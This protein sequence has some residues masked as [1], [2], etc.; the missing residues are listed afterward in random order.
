M[1]EQITDALGTLGGFGFDADKTA[2]PPTAAPGPRNM[3][4]LLAA[5]ALA[6]RTSEG[7]IEEDLSQDDAADKALRKFYELY[8]HPVLA[9]KL[10]LVRDYEIEIEDLTTHTN[11]D[12]G[13][14]R[15]GV[16][17]ATRDVFSW[18]ATAIDP[19]TRGALA[20]RPAGREEWFAN[21]APEP[22]SGLV[23]LG[24]KLDNTQRFTLQTV[25]E[26]QITRSVTLAAKSSAEQARRA[27]TPEEVD[28]HLPQLRTYGI[29]LMD[30][31]RLEEEASRLGSAIAAEALTEAQTPLIFAE[32][33]T[34]GMRVDIGIAQDSEFVW[35]DAGERDIAYGLVRGT[36]ISVNLDTATPE[37]DAL[38]ER[39]TAYFTPLNRFLDDPVATS[40]DGKSAVV[41]GRPDVVVQETLL[42]WSGRALS[43]PRRSRRDEFSLDPFFAPMQDIADG[44]L[45]IELD[46]REATV[47]PQE[48]IKDGIATG[49]PPLWEQMGYV[50]GARPVYLNRG[51]P[52][53]REARV[54]YEDAS[55]PLA[56]GDGYL[57][58]GRPAP[59]I[60]GRNEP[61][62]APQLLLPATANEPLF[63]AEDIA[64]WPGNSVDTLI[65]RDAGYDEVAD[66]ERYILPPRI[67]VTTAE[68]TGVLADA[69]VDS[70]QDGAITRPKG[71]FSRRSVR[72]VDWSGGFPSAI[73]G[74]IAVDPPRPVQ[75][76]D[77]DPDDLANDPL[78][79]A[80][81]TSVLEQVTRG[82]VFMQGEETPVEFPYYPD[83]LAVFL[84]VMPIRDDRALLSEP[85]RIRVLEEGARWPDL[86]P[87]LIQLARPGSSNRA[88][89]VVENEDA[90]VALFLLDTD[91]GPLGRTVPT[92]RVEVAEGRSCR[93][94][95]WFAPADESFIKG[96]NLIRLAAA[97]AMAGADRFKSGDAALRASGLVDLLQ[98]APLRSL[99]TMEHL[100]LTN[101]TQRPVAAPTLLPVE[102]PVLRTV[103]WD[104][105]E[106][107]AA[108]MN[109][110][111]PEAGAPEKPA[112]QPKQATIAVIDDAL[113]AHG[114][115][116][117]P[118]DPTEALDPNATTLMFGGDV[119]VHR[120]STAELRI[121]AKWE[122]WTD[123]IT[124]PARRQEAEFLRP[125][126]PTQG[127]G[128]TILD[129]TQTPVEN[130]PDEPNAPV[131]LLRD[132]AGV[133]RCLIYDFVDT[134]ARELTVRI[135]ALSRHAP[136]FPA[137]QDPEAFVTPGPEVAIKVP[138][139]A[140]PAEPSLAEPMLPVFSEER[141]TIVSGSLN[142]PNRTGVV[143]TRATKLRFFLNRPWYDAGQGQRLAVLLWDGAVLD[144]DTP[145]E[146]DKVETKPSDIPERM[147]T[148]V[149]LHGRDPKFA[150]TSL[151]DFITGADFIGV[152]QTDRMAHL[153]LPDVADPSGDT[154]KVSAVLF[155]AKLD[156]VC[157][158]WIVDVPMA[159]RRSYMPFV[160]LSLAA[161]Q[162][163]SRPGLE[164]SRPIEAFG[165]IPPAR[166]AR[167][168]VEW[169]NNAP[170]DD[171][172]IMVDGGS[173]VQREPGEILQEVKATADA[174]W[175][176]VLFVERA[177][178]AEGS[179]GWVPKPNDIGE[180]HAAFK[181]PAPIQ[182]GSAGAWVSDKLWDF[183]LKMPSD[184][185]DL[186]GAAD[187]A[188]LIREYE[189][190]AADADGPA[191]DLD[192]AS[193]QALKIVEAFHT[194]PDGLSSIV[195][196]KTT[197][198]AKFTM[199]ELFG[200]EPSAPNSQK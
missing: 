114:G 51:G 50:L 189:R 113:K 42:T 83:P 173:Y 187:R 4:E 26:E 147:R 132:D 159:A 148:F 32:T 24:E 36:D 34:I 7:V 64:K 101:A 75:F 172:A 39:T 41:G 17:T 57:T 6:R 16:R 35:F 151:P 125:F 153:T 67:D 198:A 59:L 82:G 163:N 185:A 54:H 186:K 49:V 126:A 81:E 71:M 180:D 183:A 140:R 154:E 40:P 174:P 43:L 115:T 96:H 62:A 12:A 22:S 105:S 150:S 87:C 191:P 136:V 175:L 170:S 63:S 197:F 30:R 169:E 181:Q 77:N 188:V 44:P 5:A 184:W 135:A 158:V 93:L 141:I 91:R 122:E 84:C 19:N 103:R 90:G 1:Q 52:A 95:T 167:L 98:S 162:P 146:V 176:E 55:A 99:T 178:G 120:P 112:L 110:P 66:V 182:A 15:V 92:L 104:L 107:V 116:T 102:A 171:L 72:Q 53:L 161:C 76:T 138:A 168:S 48:P 14:L 27:E 46:Y 2:L 70:F 56:L 155:E 123:D 131:N 65:L 8:A 20:F 128:W 118:T 179:G 129:G 68:V 28:D 45:P 80:S 127:D 143:L 38:R 69:E 60:F 130:L 79:T 177:A 200:Q 29:A 139:T 23:N 124:R 61:I 108:A 192:E 156:A 11:G 18:T 142:H 73:G 194:S 78:S 100:T 144:P 157:D 21:G 199:Q 134:R 152:P 31:G 33:L 196:G 89:L 94:C 166:E 106:G 195:R 58:D 97:S 119:A 160:R 193:V 13:F 47:D 117:L 10:G 165:R 121:E 109:P 164:L 88:N 86:L 133:P 137:M 149:S 190:V 145:S 37:R 85:A 25:D 74:G 3:G 9:E 111:A